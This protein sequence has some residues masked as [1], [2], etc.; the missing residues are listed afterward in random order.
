MLKKWYLIDFLILIKSSILSLYLL[1]LNF[2]DINYTKIILIFSLTLFFNCKNSPKKQKEIT[3]EINEMTYDE[4]TS[5]SNSNSL[6]GWHL[7]QNE[8][9]EKTGWSVKDGIFTFNSE[10]ANGEGNKSLITNEK[11]SSFEIQFEWKLSSNSNSGFMWGVSEDSQY[12][13]PYLTGPE[14]QI[15]DADIYGDDPENQIHTTAALYD[16][17]APDRVMAKDAGEWNTYHI[18][19]N[20]EGNSGTVIHNGEEINRFPLYGDEWDAMVENSKFS[21]MKGFGKY[22]EG[23]LCLQDHPGIIS[24]R[25]IKIKRL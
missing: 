22:Q 11:Y 3:P 15:I 13:H 1:K 24:Y 9:G 4:W 14:I 25:N 19:I 8:S 20:Q 21:E 17:I 23:H 7:F 12:D 10:E 18:T 5:L 16:M 2:M 6:D